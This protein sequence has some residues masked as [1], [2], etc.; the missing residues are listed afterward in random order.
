MPTNDPLPDRPAP[1]NPSGKLVLLR[2]GETEWSKLGRHT[3]LTD[4]TLTAH[5]EDLARGAGELVADYNFSLILTSPLE[6]ARRTAELAGLNA[7]VD[8]SSSSGT[9]AGSKGA[10][11]E[12]SVPNSATTGALSRTV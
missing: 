6:R 10:R 4:I 9:T 1:D 12:T 5:G 11:P 7:E 8:P 3:G 2:H